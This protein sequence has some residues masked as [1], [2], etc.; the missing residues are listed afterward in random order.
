MLLPRRIQGLRRHW[1][2]RREHRG[3]SVA[4]QN[5]GPFTITPAVSEEVSQHWSNIWQKVKRL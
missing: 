4:I 2:L 5:F 1:R 3:K